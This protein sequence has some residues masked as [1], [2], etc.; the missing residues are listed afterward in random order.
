MFLRIVSALGHAL[1]RCFSVKSYI[2]FVMLTCGYHASLAQVANKHKNKDNATIGYIKP[3]FDATLSNKVRET[4]GLIWWNNQVWTHNDSGGDPA[5][6]AI[7]TATGKVLRKV[8]VTNATNVDWEDITQDDEYIYVGDFG[9]N[10]HGNRQDLKVYK[11]RK[12]DVKAKDAVVAGIIHFSYSDQTNFTPNKGASTNFDCEAFIA[13][14]DS[15]YLFSKDWLD[16][17][18]RLYKLSKQ[19]GTCTAENMGEL[20]VHGLVTGATIIPDKKVIILTGYSA[21]LKPFVYVLYDF[22][23]DRFFAGNKKKI[24]INQSFLQVE[25]I[26]PVSD[27]SFYISN[28]KFD[29]LDKLINKSAKLQTINLSTILD[30][31]YA[32][33]KSQTAP[34][35][36]YGAAPAAKSK[37]VLAAK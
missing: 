1:V 13:Y 2:V 32:T 33:L 15:L 23:G 29:R 4:S 10:K 22:S 24:G 21:L 28:E 16:N 34:V 9:N 14:N 27:T 5:L 36:K 12:S 37:T 11:I 18:T 19:P 26:C 8:T 6:F 35:A 17:K 30:P 20:N 31:Y 3:T 25:G 7:D